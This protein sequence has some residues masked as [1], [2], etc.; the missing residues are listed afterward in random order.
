MLSTND[1]SPVKTSERYVIL[2]ALRGFA[3]I[4]HLYGKFSGVFPLHV[5]FAGSGGSYAYGCGRQDYPLP[6]VY[7]CRRQVLYA[8]FP[9]VRHRLLHHHP[10]CGA[11]RD[12]RI[13]HLLPEDGVAYRTRNCLGGHC[14]SLSCR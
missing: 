3:P 6:A 12:E 13:P 5:P 9:A 10:Q 7:L 14:S 11:E 2:D 1:I 8:V 4:R